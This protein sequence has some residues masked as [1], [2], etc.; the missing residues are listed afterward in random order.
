MEEGLVEQCSKCIQNDENFFHASIGDG[1]WSLSSDTRIK[2]SSGNGNKF[3]IKCL[4]YFSNPKQKTMSSEAGWYLSALNTCNELE[5]DVNLLESLR[6]NPAKY[7]EEYFSDISN[8][9]DVRREEIKLELEKE[10][11]NL[12]DKIKQFNFE[13]MKLLNLDKKDANNEIARKLLC[14]K[15]LLE[16][17]ELDPKNWQFIENSANESCLLVKRELNSLKKKILQN[18]K[19]E[20]NTNKSLSEIINL[21]FKGEIILND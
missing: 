13:C 6:S 5:K 3:C 19:F 9:I 10:S 20:F 16:K 7:V 18:K 2:C 21:I 14:W 17:Q 1:S 11:E 15:N 8:K 4:K 12:Y